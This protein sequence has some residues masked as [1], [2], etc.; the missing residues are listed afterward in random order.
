[1]PRWPTT[2]IQTWIAAIQG[3]AQ[4]QTK[5]FPD[6]KTIDQ[7]TDAITTAY[8]SCMDP[9]EVYDTSRSATASY[10][11]FDHHSVFMAV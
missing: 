7:L 8:G 1:M 10:L 5:S 2:Q 3:D 6:I 9:G 11:P 4:G